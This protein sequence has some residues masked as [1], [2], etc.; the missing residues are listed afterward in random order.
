L[1]TSGP[2]VTLPGGLLAVASNTGRFSHQRFALV[3][4]GSIK[5]GHDITDCIRITVGY[6][7]LYWS[8]VSRPGGSIDRHVDTRQVVT[9]VNYNPAF[10]ASQPG[11]DFQDRSFWAQGLSVGLSFSY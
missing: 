6:D 7:F 2:S 9:D 4:T 8:R 3:P 5:V 11:L 10:R 1:P